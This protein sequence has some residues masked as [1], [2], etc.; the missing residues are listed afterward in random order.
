MYMYP[1][2]WLNLRAFRQNVTDMMCRKGR[3]TAV[4]FI[5][6]S[7]M[8][9]ILTLWKCQRHFRVASSFFDPPPT[10][11]PFLPPKLQRHSALIDHS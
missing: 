9:K 6:S 5:Q 3:D 8:I 11:F 10:L 4:S 2:K 7:C 1:L